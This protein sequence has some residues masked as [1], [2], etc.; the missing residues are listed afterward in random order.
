[1]VNFFPHMLDI[2]MRLLQWPLILIKAY[3]RLDRWTKQPNCGI[4]RQE[5][6]T[7]LLE[8]MRDKSYLWISTRMEIRYW[9]ALSMEQQLYL[10]WNTDLGHKIRRTHPF[11]ARPYRINIKCSILIRRI[12]VRNSLNWQDLQTMGRG[13]RQV[14][15]GSQRTYRLDSWFQ[16]QCDWNQ[17][18][19]CFGW[20][21]HEGV[22]CC[23]LHL[24]KCAW[25]ARRGDFQGCLQPS[26]NQNSVGKFWSYCKI[27]GCWDRSD[28]AGPLRS[29]GRDIFLSVQLWRWYY[30]YGIKG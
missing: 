5:N 20:Y 22:Q 30:N 13:V 29:W 12:Y 8:D 7:Q 4:L 9:L 26:G 3:A 25:G 24:Y 14:H 11:T 28:D 27:M 17:F 19:D 6:S 21:E 23:Q 16:F 10:S 1:M 2:K 18:G 15:V